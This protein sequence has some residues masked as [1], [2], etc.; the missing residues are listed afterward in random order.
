MITEQNQTFWLNTDRSTYILRITKFGHLEHIYY[1]AKLPSASLQ[2]VEALALKHNAETGT[3]VAYSETDPLYSLDLLALEWAGVGRGDFRDPPAE[4]KMPD[5]SFVHDFIYAEHQITDD[6]LTFKLIDQS[7]QVQLKLNYQVFPAANVIKRWCRIRNQNTSPLIIRKLMSLMVDLP[8][9]NFSLTTFDGAWS[10]EAQTHTRPLAP[11]IYINSSNTGSSSNRHNPGFI[12]STSAVDSIGD[13][14]S[15]SVENDR[16]HNSKFIIQ[17]SKSE[18]VAANTVG[19]S[20]CRKEFYGFNLIYSGNHFG[21]VE[22]SNQNLVRVELGINPQ[23]FEWP[24]QTNE[25]FETPAAIMTYSDQSLDDLA[26]NFHDFVNQEIVPPTWRG[27]TRPVAFNNWE[28]TFFKFS[29]RKLLKLAHQA[30]DLG[31]EMMVLDDGWFK[32]RDSDT[33]GLGDY[34]VNR[35]KFPR[36]LKPF[37]RKIKQLGLQFGIW[38]E[39]EM[40]N[41]NSDL[42]RQHPDWVIQVPNKTPLQGRHQLVLDLCRPAVRD[43]I[44]QEVSRVLDEYQ[45]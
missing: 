9:R 35:K 43:Y 37:V 26:H 36:G 20:S 22:L 29:Q 4:I 10:K 25:S 11:G 24:L 14:S 28:A 30:Q 6:T 8:N 12:L 2:E 18:G 32:G 40:V 17:K 15:F 23:S 44:V 38:L 3:T 7:N 39:P 16:T 33:A 21:L 27:K 45:V 13:G 42:Y 5:T 41:P 19:V 34:Q 1:G 31:V